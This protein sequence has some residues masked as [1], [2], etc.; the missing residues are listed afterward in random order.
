M[1]IPFY[2]VIVNKLNFFLEGR[3]FRESYI[4]GK[5]LGTLKNEREITSPGN[6]EKDISY[7]S[8][9]AEE[10]VILT[11]TKTGNIHKIN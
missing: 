10:S 1:K 4:S 9:D 2:S 5:D 11:P 3:H 8:G 7:P 6:T